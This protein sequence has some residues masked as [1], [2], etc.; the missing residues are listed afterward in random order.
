M[1]ESEPLKEP[2][3]K[4]NRLKRQDKAIKTYLSREE[5]RIVKRRAQ[6]LGLSVPDYLRRLIHKNAKFCPVS[7]QK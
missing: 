3:R 2:G 5:A 4:K 1:N 6:D 7:E